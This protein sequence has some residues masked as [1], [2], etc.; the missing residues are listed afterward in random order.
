MVKPKVVLLIFVSGKIVLTGA[1]VRSNP[2][3]LT[4]LLELMLIGDFNLAVPRGDLR[5]FRRHLPRFIRIPKTLR[6]RRARQEADTQR[7]KNPPAF[8]PIPPTYLFFISLFAFF[9]SFDYIAFPP[10]S[11]TSPTNPLTITTLFIHNHPSSPL[12]DTNPP[13]RPPQSSPIVSIHST[14]DYALPHAYQATDYD[15][16]PSPSPNNVYEL[17]RQLII[18]SFF[19]EIEGRKKGKNGVQSEF[20]SFEAVFSL[21]QLLPPSHPP[22]FLAS[23]PHPPLLFLTLPHPVISTPPQPFSFSNIYFLLHYITQTPHE[24]LEIDFQVQAFRK[25]AS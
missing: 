15:S 3:I 19:D 6:G 9:I 11:S 18:G 21:N 24:D 1:K 8:L 7:S 2:S 10:P 13:T 17:D 22:P 5:R 16:P 4:F 20:S 12:Y 23:T 25:H 14:T